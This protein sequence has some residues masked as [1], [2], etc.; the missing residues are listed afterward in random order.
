MP[1]FYWLSRKHGPSEKHHSANVPCVWEA[2]LK[3]VAL[4]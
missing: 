4:P 1:R 3:M 2:P